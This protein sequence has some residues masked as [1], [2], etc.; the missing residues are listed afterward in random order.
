MT[1]S[2][3]ILIIVCGGM[4]SISGLVPDSFGQEGRNGGRLFDAIDSNRDDRI[5]PDELADDALFRM[6][7][8]NRDGEIVQV[9]SRSAFLAMKAV[10]RRQITRKLAV[11][12]QSSQP[13]IDKQL[14][15][16]DQSTWQE[17]LNEI[18]ER[19][20]SLQDVAGGSLRVVIDRKIV[21]DRGFGTFGKELDRPWH[22]NSPVALASITKSVTATLVA[23]LV[24]Q[25]CFQFD[26]PISNYLPEYA[27]LQINGQPI[28]SPTIAE[29]LSH[30]SGFPGGTMTRLPADSPIRKANQR[31]VARLIATQGL[32]R[33]PGTRFAYTFRGYAIIAAVIEEKLDKRFADVL[34]DQ[35]LAPLKMDRTTFEPDF[36]T[37]L[38]MPIYADRL[39]GR[40][41]EQAKQQM[42][43]LRS[44]QPKFV[45]AAGGLVSTADDMQRFLQLHLD[46]GEVEGKLFIRPE[47]LQRL[48][49][50]APAC[51]DY[52]LGFKIHRYG[53][54]RSIGHGGATGTG[55]YFD[56]LSKRLLIAFTQSR[57][58]GSSA[59]VA[60][61][62]KAVFAGTD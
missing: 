16:A 9:E 35:L 3:R 25:G 15:T 55:A 30:T 10:E 47:T 45:N 52:G 27:T 20:V 8:Q 50:V 29:C 44:L 21:F 18:G 56:P 51:E 57:K 38:K 34:A 4:L 14:R 42:T 40:D 2:V 12:V 62:Q 22:T 36:E 5:T 1:I 11:L 28:R 59:L 37:V 41:P 26:D 53:D 49:Q 60:P 33:K 23:L 31:E 58:A 43:R 17:K 39:A 61:A 13:A 32:V 48:Y 46:R 6:L 24:D 19:A 54:R 7:D